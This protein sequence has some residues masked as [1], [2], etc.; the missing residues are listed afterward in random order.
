MFNQN[1]VIGGFQ[2]G[3]YDFADIQPTTVNWTRQSFFASLVNPKIKWKYP[4]EESII[5][6]SP[7]ID[8][9]GN[10]YF[11][12]SNGNLYAF[13]SGGKLN[14]KLQLG[15]C[16]ETPTIGRDG[17]IYI[18]SRNAKFYAV[19]SDG[20]EKWH[21]KAGDIIE[22]SAAIA[23][24]GTIYFSSYDRKLY[25][26][27][28]DGSLKW[29]FE[30]MSDT[31]FWS[32]P[33]IAIDGTIYIGAGNDLIA[34]KPNG[35]QKW[36]YSIGYSYNSA[37]IIGV[38][39]NIYIEAYLNNEKKIYAIAKEGIKKWEFKSN[40]GDVCTSPAIGKGGN[41]FFGTDCFKLLNVD[42][43]GNEIWDVDVEGFM[44]YPPIITSDGVIYTISSN[45]KNRYM[46]S[47]ITAINFD[48]TKKWV[49]TLDGNITSPAIGQN[50][51]IYVLSNDTDKG[52][53]TLYAICD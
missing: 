25:A 40:K 15:G 38:D 8:R 41:L 29:Y 27:K 35:S 4:L 7:V 42:L 52:K 14:W 24:D 20:K 39:G 18:G 50:R 13:D 31:V 43:N 3:A 21:F 10:L 45:E 26:I 22:F 16:L 6:S 47:W 51:I 1:N 11:G 34:I 49:I 28:N 46:S 36:A 33:V 2:E 23:S 12:G 37:P 9:Y 53:G 5:N 19:T 48:G 17:T 44:Y 32:S 30:N